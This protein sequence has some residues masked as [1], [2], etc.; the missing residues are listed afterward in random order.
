MAAD[1]EQFLQ[2]IERNGH[3]ELG[4]AATQATEAA[5]AKFRIQEEERD[6]TNNYIMEQ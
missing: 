5:L 1:N 4:K 3:T 2:Y 6:R